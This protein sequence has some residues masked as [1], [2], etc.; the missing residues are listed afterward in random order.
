MTNFEEYAKV[1]PQEI[2][3][4][5]ATKRRFVETLS[6][7]YEL[8]GEV[9][10]ITYHRDSERNIEIVFIHYPGGVTKINVTGNSIQ[11]T[12]KEIANQIYGI[13]AVGL[14]R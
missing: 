3:E 8:A 4:M 10:K 7:A 1:T 11:A 6:E 13:D 12:G 5:Y 9:T 2:A 14:I